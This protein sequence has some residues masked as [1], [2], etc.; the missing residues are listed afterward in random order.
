MLAFIFAGLVVA[1]DQ[2]FKRWVSRAL[3]VVN[4]YGETVM[5]PMEIIPGV[6]GLTFLENPGAM[7]G[8]LSGQRWILAGIA[9]ISAIILIMIILRYNE[10][11]WGTLGLAAALG[12]T[13]GNLFDRIFNS[14]AVIDMF[15]TL[16][17]NFPIFNIAD[18]FITLGFFTFLVH[19]ISMSFK[20][21]K[22]TS[23]AGGHGYDDYDGDDYDQD[24]DEQGYGDQGYDDQG[25]DSQGY[26]D[27]GYGS[28]ESY[29]DDYNEFPA[30]D[31]FVDTGSDYEPSQYPADDQYGNAEYYAPESDVVMPGMYDPTTDTTPDTSYSLYELESDV[32]S[33]EDYNVDDIDIDDLLREYGV[34]I[35]DN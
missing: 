31:S 25:Y 13:V 32:G 30:M 8:L 27:Q 23:P 14:G 9:L 10:G 18:I 1:L 3:F 28:H 12:G 15:Q 33:L 7:L 21:K 22:K 24:Y 16:F 5:E 4:D 19:F 6:I 17:I 34:D 2:F 11:F 26:G 29:G 35:D 20:E